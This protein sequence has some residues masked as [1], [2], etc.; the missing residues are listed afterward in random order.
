MPE[1]PQ[2][3]FLLGTV[4][5]QDEQGVLDQFRSHRAVALLVYLVCQ[6]HP[7][8]RSELVELIWPDMPLARGQANLRWALSYC[9]KLLPGCWEVTRQTAQFRADA[10][11]R[12]DVLALQAA[13]TAN[14]GRGLET[15]VSN[16]QGEFCR[17]LYFD[18]SPE[19]ETW[20]LTQREYWRQ[21]LSAAWQ[22]LIDHYSHPGRYEQ[23]LTFARELL[24]LDTWQESAQRQVMLL[25]ARSGDC[26]GALAQ[27]ETCRRLLA[28]KLGVE[29]M[30]VTK[31]LYQR[32]LAVRGRPRHNL[33]VHPTPFIGREAELSG[34]TQL[35]AAPENRLVTIVAPG[36][37]G[38]TRLALAAAAQQVDSF[39]E[40]VAFV[41]LASLESPALLATTI[42]ESLSRAGLI[43]AHQGH[44]RA[45]DHLLAE[46]AAVEMLLVLDNYEHLLPDV[47]LLMAILAGAPQVKL[48][49]TSRE[50]LP[51]R[52]ERPFP[53][54][55]LPCPTSPHDP[56][57]QQCDASRL[58]LHI[59][60]QVNPHYQPEPADQ[61]AIIHICQLVEG[62]P[63]A[64][65][66]AAA[67]VRVQ[68]P[69]VI[70]AEI[71]RNLAVLRTQQ[72]DL[73]PRQRSMHAVF[74]QTWSRL[75][76][77]EQLVLARM[78]VFRGPFTYEAAHSV[79]GAG[80]SILASLGDKSL[81]RQRQAGK[82]LET[83]VFFELHELLRQYAAE[84][85]AAQGWDA[86]TRQ[87][88]GRYYAELLASYEPRLHDGK[89][90]ASTL[91]EMREEIDN[92]RV[93]WEWALS[94]RMGDSLNQM[95]ESMYQFYVLPALVRDG[96][97]VM[98]AAVAQFHPSDG[99]VK[100]D[101][102]LAYGRILARLGAFTWLLHEDYQAAEQQLHQS[103]GVL[104]SKP[105][106][107]KWRRCCTPWAIL[108]IPGIWQ[109]GTIIGG[110]VWAFTGRLA[111]WRGRAPFCVICA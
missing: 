106:P 40:G 9:K 73:P 89:L 34:L 49:V 91:Q 85:L 68:T 109:P 65:E 90:E 21:Q 78:S 96:Q 56:D 1:Q 105:R 36:G 92:I 37:V 24:N 70:A 93:A 81:L 102:G 61:S 82:G 46:L 101:L 33:P 23:A 60:A 77:A 76:Q 47:S 100:S 97:A 30:P 58:F 6:D 7:V 63:L 5:I 2:H 51:T 74:D 79:T 17:G 18:E 86:D 25:L 38:K 35:L 84:R 29:P 55:G 69:A 48:L 44:K 111:I 50:R 54:Q 43:A 83:A 42:V 45:R 26:N 53:L 52:W 22:R 75:S 99:T 71:A 80:W 57:W 12:V 14:D 3:L 72:H 98:A 104:K 64:L 32:I 103:L 19:F 59:A 16:V 95:I 107:A 87:R 4:R 41:S 27:Y 15:A 108:C 39:L 13:L 10:N 94:A 62:M 8:P 11:C 110:A 20:L 28:D 88:H 66:L 67:W 31:Q